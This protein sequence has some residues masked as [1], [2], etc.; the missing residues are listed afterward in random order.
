MLQGVYQL[1]EA[2]REQLAAQGEAIESLRDY[3]IA[4]A[5]LERAA[6]GSLDTPET[7]P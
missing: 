4:N 5:E 7:M 6:G 3:W 2:R 1:L